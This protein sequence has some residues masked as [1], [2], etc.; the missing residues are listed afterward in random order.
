MA[1]PTRL[2]F[3]DVDETLIRLKSMLDFL[4]YH[5][6]VEHGHRG[7]RRAAGVREKVTA[8]AAMGVPREEM[9]RAFYRAWAGESCAVL[10]ASGRRWF[11]ERSS[12]PDFYLAGTREVLREHRAE[13]AVL[14]LVSGSFPAVLDPIAA[15]VGADHVVCTRLEERDGRLTGEIVGAPVIGDGKSEA[16]DELLRRYPGVDPADCYGYGDHVSDIPMLAAVGHPVLVGGDP[17]MRT[18]F[19]GAPTLIGG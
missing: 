9:N 7:T 13:G 8:M 5:F 1:T 19:P 12:R 6:P 18:R 11:A 10:A 4:D 16:V 2:I 15:D 3:S 14:V 17:A